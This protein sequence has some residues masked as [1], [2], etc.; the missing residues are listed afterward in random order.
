MIIG[1]ITLR[2]PTAGDCGRVRLTGYDSIYILIY[3]KFF[4]EES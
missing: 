1:N 3:M 4:M 2:L